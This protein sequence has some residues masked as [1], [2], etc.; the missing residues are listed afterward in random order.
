MKQ[1]LILIYFVLITCITVS[2][3]II[4]VPGDQ[5]TIQAGIDAAQNGD[6]VLVADSTYVENINFLGKAITVASN[7]IMDGDTNHISNTIIDGSQP[8]NPDNGSVVSFVSG[9]DT[10][11]VLCG[12]TITGG[13]G[14]IVAPN[15]AR[16]GGGVL[17]NLSGAKI[18]HN[19]ITNNV[20]NYDFSST[21]G[22]IASGPPG[23]GVLVIIENNVI[24]S[25]Q[26][27]G[28]NFETYVSSGAGIGSQT[29][30]RVSG[31]IIRDNVSFSELN[32]AAGGGFASVSS[33]YVLF[34]NNKVVG[35]KALTNATDDEGLGGGIYFVRDSTAYIRVMNNIIS[36]NEVRSEYKTRGAGIGFDRTGNYGGDVLFANNIVYSNYSTGSG[37]SRGG[38]IYLWKS[39]VKVFNNTIT[40]NSSDFGG[41][42]YS[43]DSETSVVMNSIFWG[44]T[45]NSEVYIGG[46][47][48][49]IVYS[50]IQGGWGGTGNIDSDPF[51]VDPSIFD[52][53]LQDISPC[54]QKA[55]DTIEINGVW[56]YCPPYDYDG[57]FRP[58][59]V[60]TMPD[61]G[62]YE[63]QFL[64]GIEENSSSHLPDKY[65]L[66][67]NY[68]NPFNPGTT[69]EFALPTAGFVTLSIFNILGEQVATLVSENLTAGSYKYEW[70]ASEL[71]SGIYFYRLQSVDPES[72]SGQGFVKTKKMILLR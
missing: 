56:Y 20:V 39:T 14:T 58:Y 15:I 25:N 10:N 35:N 11:S 1:F 66:A 3:Q 31:N 57:L 23:T 60:G 52:F 41:G 44:D 51:F 27:I 12:F 67:Q 64:V 42:L 69:I 30:C 13:T 28:A 45:S 16:V 4:H 37:D 40:T 54:I 46:I 7:F 70:D 9:E 32:Q 24:D 6:T 8:V 65:T 43:N 19:R 50:D 55:I 53:C 63:Y 33:D 26:T 17:C 68:P 34:T 72:S 48:P 21:G 22:G 38:G 36:N 47:A 49:E 5:P 71:T 18:C 61:M 59:P 2:A 62:A 29:N